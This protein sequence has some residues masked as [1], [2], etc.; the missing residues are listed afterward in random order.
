MFDSNISSIGKINSTEVH[1]IIGTSMLADGMDMVLDL[2]KS[3][4]LFLH[5]SRRQVD[6][7]DMFSFF[8]STPLG[9][10]HP[11]LNNPEFIE[12]IGKAAL[13]KPSNSDIYS[14][15]MAE[16]VDT[17][18]RVAKPDYMKYLF[19]ISGGALAVENGLKVAFDWKVQKNFAKGYK[20]EKGHK[21]IHFK[22]AFH[23]RSGYTMSLT[24]TDPVKV[25][26]FPKFDWPRI[27]N[28]K[29][30][31]PLEEN[32]E[33]VLQ[34]EI[35]AINQIYDAIKN[36]PDDIALIL[37]EVIQAEGGDN[38][39]RKEFLQ[40]LRE[41]AD[42]NEILLM[43]DEVQTGIGLTGKMWAHQHYVQPDI[44]S[45]GKK[46][47][48]CGIMVSDRIDD[49]E[50]H[51]FRKSSRINST[52]GGNLVDMVRSAKFL[53]IIEEE[54]LVENAAKV[55]EYLL[56]NLTTLQNE[57]PQLV[58]QVRGLGLMCAFDFPTPE[59]RNKFLNELYAN[60]VVMLGCGE[61]SIR[62]RPPL[63]VQKQHIDMA[64]EKIRTTLSSL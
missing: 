48:V 34:S 26:Y 1:K 59:L 30:K 3:E 28:P 25:K 21:V 36:N 42:E 24:N 55:G 11:K 6:F 5:D 41:I 40:K 18:N 29:I 19:L 43:F 17:F 64:M 8:A 20:E 49:V 61:K 15:E 47:Q 38:F 33:E 31:F 57:F 7:L 39:F 54:N 44:L 27:I 62:F 14:V 50:N 58:S 2:Q 46:A 51:C 63:N 32:L 16:F 56:E 37:I 53:E 23:G 13:N 45:F 4:G 52:W 10:N 35:E 22:Q 60:H 12:K 9:L